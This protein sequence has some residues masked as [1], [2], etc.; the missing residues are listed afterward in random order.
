M[1][2]ESNEAYETMLDKIDEV[3]DNF[4]DAWKKGA[5]PKIE[6]YLASYEGGFRFHLWMELKAVDEDYRRREKKRRKGSA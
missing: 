4:E 5:R 3:C 1:K 2:M 6:D